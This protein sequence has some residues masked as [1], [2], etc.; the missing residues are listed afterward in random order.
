VHLQLI[1]I[2]SFHRLFIGSI[3]ILDVFISFSI[4]LKVSSFSQATSLHSSNLLSLRRLFLSSDWQLFHRAR[5]RCTFKLCNAKRYYRN[6]PS[7]NSAPLAAWRCDKKDIA[8]TPI[9]RGGTPSRQTDSAPL[10]AWR[11]NSPKP[12]SSTVRLTVQYKW[13]I[14]PIKNAYHSR[15]TEA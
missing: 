8:H 9:K 4:I 10:A 15:Q 7:D 14:F 6:Q 11:C 5:D 2:N 3:Y 13:P 12:H 1:S